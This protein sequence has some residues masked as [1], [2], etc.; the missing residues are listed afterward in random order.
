MRI[1]SF[2]L[3][4]LIDSQE[5]QIRAFDDEEK[6]VRYMQEILAFLGSCSPQAS[7]PELVK[8]LSAIYEKYWGKKDG[9]A[10]VKRE[11]NDYL[12]SM[13]ETL[14]ERIR[15]CR[16]PLEAALCFARTG[17]YIDYSAVKDVSRDQLL[18]LFE[19]QQ[20]EGLDPVEYQKLLK[21]LEGASS[22][23]YLTDNCGEVVLDKL[24]IRLIKE[25][26]PGLEIRAIVRGAPVV[27]DVDLEA[28]RYVGL[29]REVP[30]LEN[31]SDIAGTVLEYL[32]PEVRRQIE[33]ADVIL[34]KGQGNFETIHGCGLNIY[35]LFLCKC[36][37]FM[38]QFQARH[39]QG[40]L[41]SEKRIK[42]QEIL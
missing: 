30:V 5:R 32:T 33:T 16:D 12:L 26:Y 2:C 39:F 28:A 19:E 24:A 9:M 31:G 18:K 20:K 38:R 17:N 35:Y 7:A 40:M 14:E 6:K 22:L 37:W 11:F 27:N 36:D 34:S 42:N 3:T 4:C 10:D 29:D 41:V 25:I 1:N 13:E 15:S 21:D 23:I 8:P